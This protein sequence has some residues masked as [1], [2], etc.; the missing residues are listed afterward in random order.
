MVVCGS[1][2][3]VYVVSFLSISGVIV[4]ICNRVRAVL[5]GS[6]FF[7]S[8]SC[9]VRIDIFSDRIWKLALCVGAT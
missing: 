9:K 4:V 1:T 8:H 7:C 6:C 3:L 5:V 2:F